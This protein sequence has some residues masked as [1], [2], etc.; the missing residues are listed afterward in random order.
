[1][2][3]HSHSHSPS[4]SASFPFSAKISPENDENDASTT[5]PQLPL[6]NL[7]MLQ[8]RVDFLQ[9]FLYQ[10]VQRNTLICRD[11]MD[12]VSNEIDSVIQ[13]VILNG[14]SLLACYQ[15]EA[16]I[17][18]EDLKPPHPDPDVPK[19][20]L[21]ASSSSSSSIEI[22]DKKKRVKDEI[23]DGD[24]DIV[25]LDAVELLAVNIHRCEICGKG[26]K[27]DANLRMHK[28]AHGNQFK[29]LEALT[30][31]DRK[32]RGYLRTKTRFSCPF[33]GCTRNKSHGSFKPLKS[34]ICLKN[35]FK[36]SHCPKLFSC[37]RC[38]KKS[39][40]V[41]SDLKSHQK[42]CGKLKWRCSC[43]WS[44]P[45]K[46]KLFGHMALFEGHMPAFVAEEDAESKRAARK[47]DDDE[48]LEDHYDEEEMEEVKPNPN[49]S[50]D[51]TML[52]DGMLQLESFGG[53]IG[54]QCLSSNTPSSVADQFQDIW[55]SGP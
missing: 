55:W 16:P 17:L 12:L 43:G 34:A 30:R 32:E 3:S 6:L 45:R 27:R 8:Q 2:D 50:R 36:R 49:Y 18:Q 47:E 52:L 20:A 19:A 11:Q 33:N 4:L 24:Y 54:G 14:I 5:D 44:F 15:Q 22:S 35:H 1:M 53:I 31:P 38:N 28:R 29:T 48:E 7:S 25:E 42:H 46:D 40:S 51:D 23:D 21:I 10:N 26:F 37:N 39:F 9:Q 13:Q 41:V